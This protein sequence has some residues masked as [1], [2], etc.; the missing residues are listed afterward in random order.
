M[1]LNRDRIEGKIEILGCGRNHYVFVDSD[2]NLH[3]FGNLFKT[4]AEE[5]YDGYGIYDGNEHGISGTATGADGS[6]LSSLLDLGAKYQNVPGGTAS[7]TFH[8][9]AADARSVFLKSSN[10]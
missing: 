4:P 5:Q 10:S 9:V 2:N 6:D 3:C 7:W 8:I 1:R